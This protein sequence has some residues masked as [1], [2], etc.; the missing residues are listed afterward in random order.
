MED[1]IYTDVTIEQYHENKTHVSATTLKYAKESLKHYK[2]FLDGKIEREK[3]SQFSFGN[4][5]ELALLA[6]SEYLEKVAVMPEADWFGEVM[7]GKP[8]TKTVRNTNLYKALR[9]EWMLNNKGKYVINDT[10]PES[11]ETIEEMLSSCYQDSTIQDLIKNTEY[12]LSLFWTDEESGIKMKT[13]PD[14]CKRNKNVIVN[15]KTTLDGSPQAFSKDIAKWEYAL[16]AAIESQGCLRT[17]LMDSVDKYFWLVV[18]KV[19][20]FNATIYEF[21]ERDLAAVYDNL[22]YVLSRI[23]KAQDQNIWPGYG[24]AADN[25]YGILTAVMPA[26]YKF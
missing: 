9:D 17:G 20:P 25:Q 11:F 23:A 14:I 3:K 8:D 4:A 26:W 7:K 18:E 19:A 1:G 2:W 5:F 15:L 13:R 21:N 22:R 6:P 24:D 12:Q 16:Q 10:G